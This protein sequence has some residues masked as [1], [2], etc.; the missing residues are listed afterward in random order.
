MR[1]VERDIIPMCEAEGMAIAPWAAL[2][3][4]N[5]KTE[6][7]IAKKDGRQMGPPS[8]GDVKVSKVLEQIAKKKDT[9]ITSVVRIFRS[10][11]T[12]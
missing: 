10:H 12:P 11:P 2:G 7:E 6:E 5:F 1:D 9:V 4:G 3:G 8:E